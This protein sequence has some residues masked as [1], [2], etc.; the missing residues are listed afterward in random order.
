MRVAGGT[1]RDIFV[2]SANT[3]NATVQ[4]L[5]LAAAVNRK[6]RVK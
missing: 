6:S 5:S 4:N 3:D 2:S 1:D